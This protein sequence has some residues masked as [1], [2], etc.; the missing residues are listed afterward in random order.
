MIFEKDIGNFGKVY[1]LLFHRNGKIRTKILQKYLPALARKDALYYL[2][3]IKQVIEN[4]HDFLFN[5][6]F[7]E[8][9]CVVSVP[10][11]TKMCSNKSVHLARSRSSFV[12]KCS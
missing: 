6:E 3:V 8:N 4:V 1:I 11:G 7:L 2:F 10:S 12:S 5:V 9:A